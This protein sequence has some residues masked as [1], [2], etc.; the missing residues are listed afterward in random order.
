[1]RQKT[2][3]Q[4]L[5]SDLDE[6]LPFG[7]RFCVSKA[8]QL[9]SQDFSEE[10]VTEAEA[11]ECLQRSLEAGSWRSKWIACSQAR[12]RQNYRDSKIFALFQQRMKQEKDCWKK[13][14]IVKVNINSSYGLSLL[15][16]NV[17]YELSKCNCFSK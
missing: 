15:M 9:N 12:V 10:E 1:M 2:H 13:C 17:S 5:L 11:K 16:W 3:V 4:A 8:E 14:S 6:A 7:F